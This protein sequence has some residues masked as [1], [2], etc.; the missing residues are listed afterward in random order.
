[1]IKGFKE[2]LMRGNVIDLA[3]AVVIGAAFT[4]VINAV[5]KGFIDPLIAAIFGKPNLDDVLVFTI[6]NAQFSI[7]MILTALLNFVLVAAAVYFVVVLPINAINNRRRRGIP[8]P[9]VP[10]SEADLLTEIRDLLAAERGS[11]SGPTTGSSQLP[12]VV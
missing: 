8:D 4:M 9:E 11:G 3:V 1:M 7:G 12:P 6:H 10:P 5:V 2:F